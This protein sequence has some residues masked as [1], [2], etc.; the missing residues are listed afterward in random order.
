MRDIPPGTVMLLPQHVDSTMIACA[1]SCM[2]KF[3]LEFVCG[4]RPPGLSADLFAGGCFATAL[5][6]IGRLVWKDGKSLPEAMLLGQGAFAQ[7]WGDY[8]P[9]PWK[10]TKTYDRMWAAV[11]KYFEVWPPLTDHIRPYI[12]AD[13]NPTFEYTFS[14]PLEPAIAFDPSRYL[15]QV[16]QTNC[17]P[18]HPN[19]GPFFYTGRFDLLGEYN[20]RPIPRDEKTATGIGDKWAEQWQLRSQFIGYVWALRQC[21]LQAE[22]VC[23]RAIAPLMGD[24]KVAEAIV[25]YSLVVQE[26]WHEVL[27]RDLWEIVKSYEEGYFKYDFSEA[28]TA[29]GNCQFL[30]A[31]S[32]A[33]PKN[34]LNQFEIRRWNP[35]L[36]NPTAEI[37]DAVDGTRV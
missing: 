35:L 12:A 32:S 33:Q 7:A 2:R 36:K 3:L 15:Q 17:F 21:G 27:R 30:T 29:Y 16:E 25:P 26:K 8:Q 1:R 18:Q 24:V 23:V 34:W 22:E 13:G 20:G 14:V 37:K 6:A 5:E 28:C 11:E 10:K 4:Y 19:G 9:P 31:C